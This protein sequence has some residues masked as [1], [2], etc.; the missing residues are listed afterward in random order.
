M[1]IDA[2]L[3]V[4]FERKWNRL[5]AYLEDDQILALAAVDLLWERHGDDVCR[6]ERLKAYHAK[7]LRECKQQL[8]GLRTRKTAASKSDSTPLF[9][10]SFRRRMDGNG[11]LTLPSYW[12]NEL[13]KPSFVC[14]CR[15]KVDGEVCLLADRDAD[16]V[17]AREA[18]VVRRVVDD[19]GRI[20][21][22]AEWQRNWMGAGVVLI[23]KLRYA[24]IGT[25]RDGVSSK[26]GK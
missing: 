6:S 11:L 12:L 23:G 21:I 19:R 8:D 24:V 18:K 7:R 17:S 5:R 2:K 9:V 10:G 15:K 14:L 26:N 3:P 4:A 16:A 22:P 20:S 13:G 1:T 25:C